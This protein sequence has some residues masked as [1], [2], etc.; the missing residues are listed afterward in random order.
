[1]FGEV[2]LGVS[3]VGSLS[4]DV[5]GG[6]SGHEVVA[7]VADRFVDFEAAGWLLG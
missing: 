3:A 7:L 5:A 2:R 6:A 4:E 1:M